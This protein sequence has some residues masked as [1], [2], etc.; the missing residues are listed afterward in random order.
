MRS[1]IKNMFILKNHIMNRV[2]I[3]TCLGDFNSIRME[4][5]KF[6]STVILLDFR[7]N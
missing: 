3:P 2:S 6:H 4:K 1:F 5:T 7:K